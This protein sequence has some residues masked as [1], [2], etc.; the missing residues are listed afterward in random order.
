MPYP[1]LIDLKPISEEKTLKKYMIF[2]CG[3]FIWFGSLAFVYT[4]KC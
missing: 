3:L 2:C 1:P 4:M